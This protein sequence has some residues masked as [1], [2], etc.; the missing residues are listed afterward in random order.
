MAKKKTTDDA[1]LEKQI[2]V[3]LSA[4]DYARLERLAK[5]HLSIATIAR[6][7]LTVGLD[8]IEKQ[9]GVLVGETPKRR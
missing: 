4:E 1:S 8:I 6:A 9:P 2:G 3:R 7:A 5:A